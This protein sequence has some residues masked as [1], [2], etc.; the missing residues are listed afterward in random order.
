MC[1]LNAILLGTDKGGASVHPS[2][3]NYLP[4][5]PPDTSAGER[6][7]GEDQGKGCK[8]LS[9]RMVTKPRGGAGRGGAGTRCSERRRSRRRGPLLLLLLWCESHLL[10]YLHGTQAIIRRQRSPRPTAPRPHRPALHSPAPP[11]LVK[12]LSLLSRPDQP[13]P[14]SAIQ[15]ES[16]TTRTQDKLAGCIA[17]SDAFH[18]T[19]YAHSR[20]Y[21]LPAARVLQGLLLIEAVR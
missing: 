12:C 11:R 16:R 9:L 8:P 19:P 2:A 21:G 15:P 5:H 4:P 6:K 10:W 1:I 18:S 7:L 17:G 3:P 14:R 13:T 20:N